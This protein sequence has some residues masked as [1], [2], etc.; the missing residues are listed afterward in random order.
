MKR[1]KKKAPLHIAKMENL[2]Q[3]N[4]HA[5][6]IDIGL[7][8]IFVCVPQDS[9]P[10]PVR[11]FDTFTVDL[12]KIANWLLACK[13]TSVAMESTS[14]Y[15]IPLYEILIEKGI[16]VCLVNAKQPSHL[17]G[18]K[19]DLLDCQWLQQ[20]HTYGLLSSSFL[21]DDPLKPLRALL[22]HRDNLIRYR[23]SHI[24]HLQ[25]ALHLMNIQL[26]TVISDITG[27]TGMAIIRAIV[28]GERDPVV[29]ARF[30]HPMCAN[31]EDVIAKSL[32]GHYQPEYLFQLKQALD[33]YDHYTQLLKAC[34]Q[35]LQKVYA[36]ISSKINP[37]DKPL[38]KRKR[39]IVRPQRH[40]PDFDLRSE[41]Y[42]ITGVDLTAVHGLEVVTIQTVL[43]ES[44]IDMTPWPTDKHFAAWLGLSPENQS[45]GGKVL[46]SKTRKNKNRAA[47][48]LRL[49]ARNLRH[50]N[51]ALGAYYRRMRAKLGAPKAITAAAHKL[52]RIL[53]HMLKYQVEFVDSG[54]EAYEAK[55]REREIKKLEKRA[56]QLGC[57]LVVEPLVATA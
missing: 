54:A 44:G 53:Y 42:R 52:A 21:P 48:A 56:A 1:K 19:S 24:Q 38:P 12:H 36:A 16:H 8:E 23:A 10:T 57:T 20:V 9:D 2:K 40:E 33:L 22:R 29:L 35:E 4:L 37:K 47:R 31:S 34:D 55:Y 11:V 27:T 41:L 32:E 50:S 14:I 25:K 43:G 51:S 28:A 26:D 7:T 30:R 46:R 45:S 3:I 13:V 5:A 6:G 17:P 39:R 15:W 18:R 49:A